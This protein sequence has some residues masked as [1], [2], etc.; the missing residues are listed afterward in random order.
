MEL[1]R[2]SVAPLVLKFGNHQEQAGCKGVS[3]REE[4]GMRKGVESHLAG[5][6]SSI[7]AP[8]KNQRKDD[9][10]SPLMYLDDIVVLE[11]QLPAYSLCVS[12]K[13]LPICQEVQLWVSL[14]LLPVS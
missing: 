14:Q 4:E 8:C 13:Q 10:L 12:M 2:R 6:G 1:F 5:L 7:L 3:R 9:M 11:H